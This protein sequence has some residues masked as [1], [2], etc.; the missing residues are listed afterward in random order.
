MLDPSILQIID[1]LGLYQ[2]NL[3]FLLLLL[4]RDTFPMETNP[5]P[6]TFDWADDG[7][8]HTLPRASRN[9]RILQQC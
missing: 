4:L 9:I 6:S 5:T 1:R 2:I 3:G 7:S 8:V